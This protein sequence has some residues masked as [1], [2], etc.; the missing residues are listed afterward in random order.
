MNNEGCASKKKY[1]PQSIE[2]IKKLNNPIFELNFVTLNRLLGS[3]S[4]STV[5]T[6]LFSTVG[7]GSR[8]GRLEGFLG[9]GFQII[10]DALDGY[11]LGPGIVHDIT[12]LRVPIPGLAY[13]SHIHQI[14]AILFQRIFGLF[15]Y[16]Y[17]AIRLLLGNERFMHMP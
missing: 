16:L 6:F 10:G 5:I 14:T 9:G 17:G 2:P 12:G 13:T 8:R 11:L 1:A 4:N 7:R 3:G 15:Q